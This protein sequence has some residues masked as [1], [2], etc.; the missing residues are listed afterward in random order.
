MAGK[1][2][3]TSSSKPTNTKNAANLQRRFFVF[4]SL[5]GSLTLT[6]LG[7][8]VLSPPPVSAP[9]R[10]SAIQP[11]EQVTARPSLE[12]TWK[13]IYIHQSKMHQSE[14]SLLGSDE[15]TDHFVISTTPAGDCEVLTSPRWKAQLA[16]LPPRGAKSLPADCISICLIGDF[17][18]FQPSYA[19]M[20]RLAELVNLLQS[21]HRISSRGVFSMDVV[22]SPVGIGK[23]F[24]AREFQ[25]RVLP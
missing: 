6:G 7:L 21:K 10:L 18:R 3:S 19:Q 13:S 22:G 24:P 15:I 5:A 8:K 1:A 17:D 2:A 25:K 20:E 16:A 9:E 11:I 14:F 12:R 4:L 23:R